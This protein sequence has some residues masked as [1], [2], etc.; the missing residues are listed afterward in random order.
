MMLLAALLAQAAVP[1]PAAPGVQPASPRTL[2]GR[3]ACE[4]VVYEVQVTAAPL[5]GTG[6]VLDRLVVDGKAVDAGSLA[7]ARRMAVRLS[8]VQSMDVRCRADGA[9]ELSIYGTQVAAGAAPRRA[10][11]RGL[12]QGAGVSGLAMAVAR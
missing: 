5:V 4:A 10:R 1:A 8:D 3:F 9:G 12:L 6:V 11:L 7:E 2:T